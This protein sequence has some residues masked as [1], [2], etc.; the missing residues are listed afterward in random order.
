MAA[1]FGIMSAGLGG[2]AVA[3][4]SAGA[5]AVTSA[6]SFEKAMTPVRVF[7]DLTAQQTDKL[8]GSVLQMSRTWGVAAGEIAKGETALVK[9]GA[10]FA[11]LNGP[12]AE[13]V[14][15]LNLASEGELDMGQSADIVTQGLRSWKLPASEAINFVNA[16]VG[17][18]NASTAGFKGMV[19]GLGQ[20]QS[21]AAATG[22][23]YRD[24]FAILGMLNDENI[25]GERA[26]T[27][28]RN[29]QLRM[30]SPTKD[31]AG[32]MARYSISLQDANGHMIDAR[33]FIERMSDA[34]GEASTS[35]KGLTKAQVDSDLATL[36]MSRSL[37]GALAIANQGTEA[38]DKYQRAIDKTDVRKIAEAFNANTVRQAG[39]FATNLNAIAI[40]FGGPFNESLGRVI[41]NMNKWLQSI[42]LQQVSAIATA[43]RDGLG[44]ALSYVGSL[45]QRGLS[46]LTSLFQRTG[47]SSTVGDVLMRS[48]GGVL[49]IMR[50]LQTTWNAIWANPRVSAG[51]ISILGSL[52]RLATGVLP[53]IGR[54]L[55]LAQVSVVALSEAISTLL[56]QAL[57]AVPWEDIGKRVDAA[58][59][60]VLNFLNGGYRQVAQDVYAYVVDVV[61]GIID[62]ASKMLAAV[63]T[64]IA[65][66]LTAIQTAIAN[67]ADSMF[68][69]VRDTLAS[70]GQFF[71]PFMSLVGSVFDSVANTVTR[72]VADIGTAIEP[73]IQFLTTDVPKALGPLVE[74]IKVAIAIVIVMDRIY[75]RAMDS[76]VHSSMEGWGKAIPLT[77]DDAIFAI[78]AFMSSVGKS[79]K[80]TIDA[81]SIISDSM[82][83]FS[84]T[85]LSE[86]RGSALAVASFGE[87]VITT[88]S[89]VYLWLE[90]QPVIGAFFKSLHTEFDAARADIEKVFDTITSAPGNAFQSVKNAIDNVIAGIDGTITSVRKSV[91]DVI[92]AVGDTVSDLGSAMQQAFDDAK[93][94]VAGIL[95]TLSSAGEG[96]RVFLEK[97]LANARASI[98]TATPEVKAFLDSI[99]SALAK[100]QQAPGAVALPGLGGKLPGGAG[101]DDTIGFPTDQAEIWKKHIADLLKMVPALTDDFVEFIAKLAQ[102]DPNRLNGM[103]AAIN[104]QRGVLQDIGKVRLE[105]LQTEIKMAQVDEKIAAQQREQQRINLEMQKAMLPYEIQLLDLRHRSLQIEQQMMPLQNAIADIDK[106]IALL[107]RENLDLRLREL[108]I[109]QQMLPITNQ[110]ADIDKQIADTQ[111][112][113]YDLEI[114][115][116]QIKE[117]MLPLQN[118]LADIEKQI[119]R[120]SQEN[121]TLTRERLQLEQAE[122]LPRR[123]IEDIDIRIAAIQRVNYELIG[124]QLEKQQELLPWREKLAA[125]DYDIAQASKTNLS[126]NT[127]LAKLDLEALP[128]K[129]RMKDLEQQITDIVDKRAQ[130][131]RDRT[132]LIAEH[133]LKAAERSIK[134]IDTQLDALWK[135]FNTSKGGARTAL[136]PQIIDLEAQK[137]TLSDT[138]KPAQELVATLKD[139]QDEINFNNE[140]TKIGLDIQKVEQEALLAPINAQIDALK[141]QQEQEQALAA[142]VK[143][144]L[145]ERKAAVEAMIEPLEHQLDLLQQ[146]QERARLQAEAAINDL[147]KEKQLWQDILDVQDAQLLAIRR[148]EEEQKLA[149]DIANSYLQ[150]QAD[151]LKKILEQYEDELTFIERQKQAYQLR[152]E[153]I[154]LG[155]EQEKSR[156]EAIN[157]SWQDQLDV[158]ERTRAAEE[159]RVGIAVTGLEK[160]KLALENLLLPLQNAKD[161]IDRQTAAITTQQTLAKDAYDKQLLSLKG[162]EIETGLYKLQLEGIRADEQTRLAT[163]ISKFQEAM[164]KS[165]AFSTA[166]ALESIKRLNLWQGEVN[167]VGELKTNYDNLLT[168]LGNSASPFGTAKT[169]IENVTPSQNAL[170][171]AVGNTNTN[172]NT[173]KTF[174]DTNATKIGG[175]SDTGSL[176]YNL[177]QAYEAANSL[178]LALTN[179]LI[180]LTTLHNNTSTYTTD[181]NQL[182]GSFNSLKDAINGA[183]G[184]LGVWSQNRIRSLA[185]EATAHQMASTLVTKYGMDPTPYGSGGAGAA[186]NFYNTMR[187]MIGTLVSYDVGGYVKGAM[188]QA[189]L[190][191][192]HGGEYVVSRPEQRDLTSAITRAIT[193]YNQQQSTTNYNFTA[194]YERQQDPITASMDMRALIEMTR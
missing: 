34:F 27:A 31:V 49:A 137:K 23:A 123:A 28:L 114:A 170:T 66:T 18:T 126:I 149:A 48:L 107:Q 119:A 171:T 109:R 152:N 158:I 58:V 138:L 65:E 187:S 112:V 7:G 37:L 55:E 144:A 61:N 60:A 129:Q 186:Q 146:I 80:D 26:G 153:I 86:L 141:R 178:T 169:A 83:A 151:N 176:R 161:A 143:T 148:I 191:M 21:M 3:A 147:N 69:T 121:Y 88:F 39:I 180:N 174:I 17:A 75:N 139:Q 74:A 132:S 106:Q 127:Q 166:E 82:F 63:G 73:L 162:I 11:D 188:G 22:I 14:T 32:V 128:A 175:A 5:A 6:A 131:E 105:I 50:N 165:G 51:I 122:L 100:M 104:A 99:T 168:S 125:I 181:V 9:A 133:D 77:I 12:L 25:R 101:A 87:S 47:V 62:G 92:G 94:T 108:N 118:D 192:V 72:V 134:N 135:K 130:L 56:P 163:L 136:I 102:A 177:S 172:L 40:T 53:I 52:E 190:A 90:Q 167:K 16:L 117:K 156:L 185:I 155:L 76:L 183:S 38:F 15:L 95:P 67:I 54:G 30:L 78:R 64:Y 194:S 45:A 68:T 36:G 98:K 8:S 173:L 115:T 46:G 84:K 43:I 120:N 2:I 97:M 10:S 41:G 159:L 124:Q 79:S 91:D 89:K 1:T 96:I 164:T 4:V 70:V 179:T 189:Q 19:A 193:T 157:R 150:E 116:A 20:S 29:L 81:M 24:L 160:Q 71:E 85:W 154:R 142:V 184:S 44:G 57:D 13:A 103:V 113:R 145:E 59:T 33:T 110:I 111:R 35:A 93:A 42:N 182:A 140:L